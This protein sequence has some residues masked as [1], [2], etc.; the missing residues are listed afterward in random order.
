[1]SLITQNE[2]HILC[3]RILESI[4]QGIIHVDN[5]DVIIYANESFCESVG[6]TKDELI[7][8]VANIFL[9]KGNNTDIINE[10]I[11]NRKKNI[12]EE[13]E[14][15]LFHKSGEPIYYNMKGF[16]FKDEMGNIT[17][18]I[19]VHI[20]VTERK[21]V[22]QKLLVAEKT[23]ERLQ[24]LVA[25]M[26]EVFFSHDLVNDKNLYI[27]PSCEEIYGYKQ[28]E[29]MESPTLWRDVIHPEDKS[30]VF[31]ESPLAE[32]PSFN[33]EYRI[34]KKDK[35]ICWVEGRIK[36]ILE[37][38]IPVRVDG[39]ITDISKRKAAERKLDLK[40][41]ELS[42]FSYKASHDLR[43]PLTS[44]RGLIKIAVEESK[45][46]VMSKYL[47]MICESTGKMDAILQDLIA[48]ALITD[49]ELQKS[50]INFKELL[51][52]ILL[53]IKFL[54]GFDKVTIT[55]EINMTEPFYTDKQC[56]HSVLFNLISNSIK[57]RD[58]SKKSIV[59]ITIK[60]EEKGTSIL[61][62]DN[63]IG[64][65][66]ELQEK[67]FEMF[68]RATEKSSGSGLG[69]YIVATTLEKLNGDIKLTSE[70][71]E[72]TSFAIQLPSMN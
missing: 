70:I 62:S 29:F 47:G 40:M 19:G 60:E 44:L 69:L 26:N 65:L 67:V 46:P 10:K 63:G 20:D 34:I 24:N 25:N 42:T 51:N 38:N 71:G 8:K 28:E 37:N 33:V 58:S 31:A 54:P 45:D 36:S 32:G 1:M 14:I 9:G 2:S 17:G 6:Y 7:G 12:S 11:E 66:P 53:T 41:K 43:S 22:E 52:E 72:G 57:Y 35:S 39:F 56:L 18:S 3:D 27:S 61:I 59:N 13:Y 23:N 50:E 21:K 48:V 30:L 64:I 49:G 55:D 15:T 4:D 68:Y 5:N 16:P